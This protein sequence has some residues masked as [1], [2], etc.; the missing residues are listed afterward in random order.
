MDVII[1]PSRAILIPGFA[2]VKAAAIASGA[3]GCSISGSG[4]SLFAL[5]KG[6]E[7]AQKVAKAMAEEFAA[8]G[9]GSEQYVSQINQ[10][11][12]V[13]LAD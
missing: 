1:E 8:L 3:L 12:P 5:S 13:I 4:P 10:K 2:Q 11:G 6:D 7:T 9:I